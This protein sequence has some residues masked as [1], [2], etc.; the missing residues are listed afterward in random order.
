MHFCSDT[1]ITTKYY[2]QPSEEAGFMEDLW[3]MMYNKVMQKSC[4][5]SNNEIC[6]L[7]TKT[8]MQDFLLLFFF[9]EGL[10]VHLRSLTQIYAPNGG[11]FLPHPPPPP[12]ACI[13]ML[14]IQYFMYKYVAKLLRFPFHMFFF[15]MYTR[16]DSLQRKY[17]SY[18]DV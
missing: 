12:K 2:S 9:L 1:K 4:T 18:E 10:G 17:V 13:Q 16:R 15:L 14:I 3:K 7:Q 6:Y 5:G 11:T 8:G